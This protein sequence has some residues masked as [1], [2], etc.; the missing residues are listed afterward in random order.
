MENRGLN[1]I[2]FVFNL[3]VNWNLYM[4]MFFLKL[5]ENWKEY[6][7]ILIFFWFRE[8]YIYINND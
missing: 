1:L 6:Y 3:E 2:V 4:C 8:F 7:I 5:F